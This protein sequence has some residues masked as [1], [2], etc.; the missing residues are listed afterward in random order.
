MSRP[1][2]GSLVLRRFL[3]R[4]RLRDGLLALSR[5]PLVQTDDDCLNISFYRA[6]ATLP[7]PNNHVVALSN[8][9]TEPIIAFAAAR[10]LGLVDRYELEL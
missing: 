9:I 7:V 6:Q 4:R 1:G 10:R 8:S 5:A 3:F 2:F